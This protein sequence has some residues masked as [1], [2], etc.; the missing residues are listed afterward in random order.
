MDELDRLR[1]ALSDHYV[2]DREIGHGGMATVYLAQDLKHDRH[3]AIKVLRPD[4]ASMLGAER[5]LREIHIEAGLQHINI[6]PVH[7]SGEAGGFL[8]YV[9]PYVDGESLRGRIDRE[10][11]LPV[12]EALHITHE[13]AEAL[14]HAHNHGIVHR[15]IKPENI[16]LSDGHA[17]LADFGIA[18]ALGAAGGKRITDAGHA[19]G[20]PLYMSPEQASGETELD[21]RSDLYSLGCVLY[22]MLAG[23]PPFTGTTTQAIIA[24]HLME[25]PPPLHVVRPTVP[26]TVGDAIEKALAKT[27]ADRFAT[28]SDFLTTLETPAEGLARQEPDRDGRDLSGL[29]PASFVRELRRRMVPHIA[30]TYLA[31]AWLA[32]ELVRTLVES[33]VLERWA[34][35]AVLLSLAL[36]L[37][38]FLV[39]AW[40]EEPK[41]QSNEATRRGRT[42]PN[43]ARKTRPFNLLTLL[44]ALVAV[45]LAAQRILPEVI[46]TVEPPID[47]GSGSTLDPTRIAVL[48]FEDHSQGEE[49]GHL[50]LVFPQYL[51]DQL[52]QLDALNVLPYAAVK[53]YYDADAPVDSVISDLNAGT[54]IEGTIIGSEDEI[55]IIVRLTDANQLAVIHSAQH[56]RPRGETLSLLDDF[57]D[58]VSGAL[59]RELGVVIR[60]LERMAGTDNNEA[61]EHYAYGRGWSE[62]AYQLWRA[63]GPEPALR[64]YERADS[65][66][67]RAQTLDPQWV[68]PIVERGW[69][70]YQKAKIQKQQLRYRDPALLEHGIELADRALELDPRSAR[71]LD[72]RGTLRYWLRETVDH[73]EAVR[74]LESAE[75]DLVA[76]T[77]IDPGNAHAWHVLGGVLGASSKPAEAKRA[78]EQA[79]EADQ[80]YEERG[81]IFARLCFTSVVSREWDEVTRWC[82]EGRAEFPSNRVIIN[83]QF[84]ALVSAGGPEPEVDKAWQLFADFLES[85]PPQDRPEVRPSALLYVAAVLARAGLSDSAK[86]VIRQAQVAEPA[87]DPMNDYNQAYV[88]LLLGDNDRALE[89]LRRYLEGMPGRKGSIA[90]DWWFESLRSDPR[91]QDLVE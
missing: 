25:D 38:F 52:S 70:T 33:A 82:E 91:F 46:A 19:V 39:A 3:V 23:E 75:Q 90:A 58:Q 76:A 73:A 86:A 77:D 42:W 71:A 65:A 24:R 10:K 50:A 2:I 81:N 62:D 14:T 16:L 29:E 61:W 51:I 34:T 44:V 31:F 48:P 41:T 9:M 83:G 85:N 43:W 7:D 53:R 17:V 78:A 5:F 49:F 30:L 35:P 4:L 8:Y 13:I 63:G 72:L 54:L 45:T 87:P 20:T 37:L 69:V 89:F 11:Q 59:R 79:L 68:D 84:L 6:L 21:G 32:T 47:A 56:R 74:L 36:G 18:R 57:T 1:S 27:P 12:E 66:F 80:F 67:V 60:D 26:A 64:T 55:L 22:E 28:A 88:W 40:A 15:D